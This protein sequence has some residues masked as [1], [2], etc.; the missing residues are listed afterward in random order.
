M[1]EPHIFQVAVFKCR[2][3]K[4]EVGGAKK[5]PPLLKIYMQ[6]AVD[7]IKALTF[8]TLETEE[9]IFFK[10]SLPLIHCHRPL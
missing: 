5:S 8:V 4:T 6:G 7:T 2:A 10:L 1:W 3:L 9:Q